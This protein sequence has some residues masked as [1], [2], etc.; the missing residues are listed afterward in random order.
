MKRASLFIGHQKFSIKLAPLDCPCVL[1]EPR[2]IIA[3]FRLFWS[4]SVS[5]FDF[6]KVGGKLITANNIFVKRVTMDSNSTLI[7]TPL[8]SKAYNLHE[9]M[10]RRFYQYPLSITIRNHQI[11]VKVD[12]EFQ[13]KYIP[14]FIALV[15]ISFF[16]GFNSC[17]FV[18][19]IKLFKRST[20]IDVEGI[21]FIVYLESSALLEYATCIVYCGATEI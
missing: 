3:L 4:L 20:Q 16:I 13:L 11:A 12:K 7:A 17:V 19:D 18:I 15:I 6:H 8:V 21:V 5:P 9:K 14:F 2:D 10:F 1:N